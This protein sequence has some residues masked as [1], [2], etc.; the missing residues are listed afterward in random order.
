MT[1][2]FMPNVYD[3]EFRLGY[4][5]DQQQRGQAESCL[6]AG[7]LAVHAYTRG[8]GVD[9]EEDSIDEGLGVV[10]LSFALR[11]FS[12]PASDEYFSAGSLTI[13][14][15]PTEFLLHER[16]IMDNFRRKSA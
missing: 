1:Q 9:L 10:V 11:L 6:Q 14:Q 4:E 12:N 8:V 5:L 2:A 16:L 13:K 3:L 7:K 15:A